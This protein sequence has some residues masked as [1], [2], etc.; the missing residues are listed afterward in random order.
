MTPKEEFARWQRVGIEPSYMVLGP[1]VHEGGDYWE[2]MDAECEHIGRFRTKD[3]AEVVAAAL[4]DYDNK[5][6]DPKYANPEGT[7]SRS[8]G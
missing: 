6:W 4:E 2:V 7:E 5:M 1:D 8:D 3:M